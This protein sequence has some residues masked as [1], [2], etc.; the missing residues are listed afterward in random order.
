MAV[1]DNPK[2]EK[3]EEAN[4]E[5]QKRRGFFHAARVFPEKHAFTPT[6]QKEIGRG[7][8]QLRQNNECA[9]NEMTRP[10]QLAASTPVQCSNW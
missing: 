4:Q 5:L 9:I 7:A 1:L 6:L 10:P 8:G 3:W 2:F